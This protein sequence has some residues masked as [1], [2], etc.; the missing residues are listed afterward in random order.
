MQTKVIFNT[1]AGLKRAAME[2]ARAKGMSLSAVLNLTTQ[3]FVDG[4]ISV[5]AVAHDIK[6]ARSQ[7][8]VPAKS[9]YK[10]FGMPL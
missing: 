4:A 1:D 8:S 10:K 9:V 6:E 7:K 5:D 3:A 2:K